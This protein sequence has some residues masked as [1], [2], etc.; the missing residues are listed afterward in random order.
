VRAVGDR[1]TPLPQATRPLVT[2]SQCAIEGYYVEVTPNRL[3]PEREFPALR[4]ALAHA[5][6][7]TELYGWRLLDLTCSAA[8]AG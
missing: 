1:C 4:G 6:R 2:V 5:G 7:L 3:M 8:D